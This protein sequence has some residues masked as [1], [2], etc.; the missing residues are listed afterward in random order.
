MISIVSHGISGTSKRLQYPRGSI[1]TTIKELGPKYHIIVGIMSPNS[2]MVVYVETLGIAAGVTGL[3]FKRTLPW[4]ALQLEG[5][6]S[7][8]GS[9]NPSPNV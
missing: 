6:Q 3:N 2:L 7:K 8:L 5:L 9:S 4:A 1:Y